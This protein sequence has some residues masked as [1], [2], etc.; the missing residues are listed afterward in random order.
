MT[1]LAIAPSWR[2]NPALTDPAQALWSEL[3]FARGPI[4]LFTMLVGAMRHCEGAHATRGDT[5]RALERQLGAWR[6]AGIVTAAG[7]PPAYSLERKYL[8]MASPP[9][10]SAPPRRNPFPKRTQR[11]RLWSAMKVLRNFDLP[12][13][14][15]TAEASRQAAMDMIR[16]LERAGW[17]RETKTGWTTAASRTWGSVAPT[18]SH[19]AGKDGS[20]IRVTE[21][22]SGAIVDLPIHPKAL[23][24]RRRESSAEGFVDGGVS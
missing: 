14:L 5:Y 3:R 21:P 1:A 4:D 7:E 18:Y 22:V 19:R 23:R 20:F 11:Q 9:A 12:T 8:R 17:L 15:M 24:D 13:L 16:V 10:L 6:D 2:I